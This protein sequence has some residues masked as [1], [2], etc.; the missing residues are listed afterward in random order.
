MSCCFFT[1]LPLMASPAVH[2]AENTVMLGAPV[3]N[4]KIFLKSLKISSDK[5][6]IAYVSKKDGGMR[7][8]VDGIPGPAY[9]GISIETPIFSSENHSIGYIAMTEN[10]MFAVIN[11][12]KGPAF[13]GVDTLTFST[14]GTRAAYRALKENNK[15]VVMVDG[16]AGPEFAKIPQEPGIV[17]SPDAKN[18]AYAGI[19]STGSHIIVQ[20]NQKQQSFEAIKTIT[21]APE[22]DH[23]AC[24]AK[25]DDMWHV[26]KDGKTG[27]PYKK[28][29]QLTFSRDGEEVAYVAQK[30][31]NRLI[32]VKN[33]EELAS[34]DAAISP[35]FS[36]DGNT[37]IYLVGKNKKWHM[38]VNGKTGPSINAPGRIGF[39]EKDE[40]FAY[41]AQI[42]DHWAVFLDGKKGPFFDKVTYMQFSP[43]DSTLVYIAHKDEKQCIVRDQQLTEFY[44][45]V[46]IPFFSGKENG[47]LAYMAMDRE[48]NKAFIVENSAG[49]S[50]SHPP[51]QMIGVLR[52]NNKGKAYYAAQRPFFSPDGLRMAYPVKDH[53]KSFMVVDGAPQNKYKAISRPYFSP[54]GNHIAY[55][56]RTGD[57]WCIVVDGREGNK[58]FDSFLKDAKIVFDTPTKC[59]VLALNTPGPSF[60]RLE[61]NIQK[62][63]K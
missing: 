44:D 39:S 40:H 25:E 17:F 49:E 36:P 60:Y 27:A 61:V 15:M 54:N 35:K 1:L 42:D 48:K 23:L 57:K 53:G 20:N 16:K 18:V 13:K 5:K 62:K 32:V 51:Y 24:V 11:G 46:G 29:D 50:K 56:A 43:Y 33:E 10:K 55:M 26:I 9:E 45:G 3:K 37:F 52:T 8:W 28:I 31:D 30:K 34:G 14:D 12:K 2:L 19:S 7:V 41:S 58:K 59:S 21:Y 6:H 22:S 47:H 38:V 4:E 63:D